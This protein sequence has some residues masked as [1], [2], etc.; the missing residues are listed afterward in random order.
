MSTSWQSNRN[1]A[2]RPP[3]SFLPLD[4]H[5]WHLLGLA[6]LLRTVT[7]P[8]ATLWRGHLAGFRDKRDQDWHK[9]SLGKVDLAWPALTPAEPGGATLG[10][11]CLLGTFGSCPCPVAFGL[12]SLFPSKVAGIF[13][14][15][16]GG[17]PKSFFWA[18]GSAEDL[19][20]PGHLQASS[21]YLYWK[22]MLVIL[23]LISSPCRISPVIS[24]S[25]LAIFS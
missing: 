9:G 15:S 19:E 24:K 23:I 6:H 8:G 17:A 3:V 11:P 21:T 20:V 1:C 22:V 5:K 12:P 16:K 2:P 13:V 4:G 18:E 7:M 14:G 10:H 25:L